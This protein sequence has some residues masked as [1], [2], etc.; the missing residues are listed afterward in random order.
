MSQ[1]SVGVQLSKVDGRSVWLFTDL[2]TIK[3]GRADTEGRYT[4]S[5]LWATPDVGPPAHIHHR[6]DESFYILEGTFEFSLSGRT[7]TAGPGS[8]VLLPKGVV[9]AHRA[10]GSAGRALIVHSPAGLEGFL[11]E[12]GTPVT[13][14]S[15]RPNP[16]DASEV[17]RVIAIAAKHGIEVPQS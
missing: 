8:F 11:E 12:A 2:H 17:G 1:R 3:A 14:R 4:L 6:E 15:V 16:P 13:D 7:F 10:I 5:E 9:H